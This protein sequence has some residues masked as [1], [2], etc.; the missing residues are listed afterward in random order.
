M[1]KICK[2]FV[3]ILVLSSGLL[4][5]FPQAALAATCSFTYDPP[6]NQ[7]MDK[8][9]V[10]VKSS[11]LA[12]GT[13]KLILK[14]SST[15]EVINRNLQFSPGPD[16]GV[17][18]EFL[19][20][21]YAG[22]QQGTHSLYFMLNNTVLGGLQNW[23]DV[24]L[25]S[26]EFS[27]SEIPT[28]QK[29]VASILTHPIEPDINV[30]LHIE[31]IADSNKSTPIDNGTQGYDIFVNKKPNQVYETKNG[32]DIDLGLFDTGTYLVSVAKRCGFFGTDCTP[33][34]RQV[35]APVAFEVASKGSG[36]GGQID[37]NQVSQ[38]TCKKK[39]DPSIVAG[40]AIC[41]ESGVEGLGCDID[42]DTPGIQTDPKKPSIK[43]AIGCIHTNPADLVADVLKFALGIGGGLA[44][45]MML[46]G[47]F[48]M[49]TSAGNPETLAAGKDRLT[50]A[51]IGLLFIIFAV[52]LLQIIGMDILGIPGFGR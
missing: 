43:T 37:P 13:Y 51:I 18:T 38:K 32:K 31:D 40:D 1:S 16:G 52:L 41:T 8:L 2:V 49:L 42:P 6:P 21:Q 45:L 33:V 23:K 24:A 20:N 26:A 17:S 30:I 34:E 15:V 7:E 39:G 12:S 35:C 48:Q 27:L 44:F 3:T 36:G 4:I 47:A 14:K 50:S 46:L 19:R 9:T 29:C 22:W 5:S 28:Q 11:D 10:T 25:C